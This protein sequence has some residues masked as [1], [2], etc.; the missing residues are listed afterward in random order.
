MIVDEWGTWYNVEPG[1]NPGFLYQQN[2]LRDAI[3][4]ALTLNIFNHH[5]DRVTMANIAQTINVLQAMIL[6]DKGRMLLTPTYHVFEMYKVHQNATLIPVELTAPEY[7][8]GDASVPAVHV[9]ASRETG[10]KIYLSL[11]NLNPN[12]NAQIAAKL[13]GANVKSVAGRILTATAMN[14]HN[15]FD[16]PET[17]KPAAFNDATVSGE[18]LK[19]T[20]PGK[21]VVVLEIQ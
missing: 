17:I 6:T 5:C 19:L 21:S 20:L 8:F 12:R 14:T 11:V 9:S 16:A 3:V 18:E 4:A 1:S 13:T 7:K 10:G 15:T 2:T